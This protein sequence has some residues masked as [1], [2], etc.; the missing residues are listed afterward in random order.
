MPVLPRRRGR[1]ARSRAEEATM[2]RDAALRSCCRCLYSANMAPSLPACVAA[3]A[4]AWRLALLPARHPKARTH[5]RRRRAWN[6][7]GAAMAYP[8]FGHRTNVCL[9]RYLLNSLQAASAGGNRSPYARRR[10]QLV[11][12]CCQAYHLPDVIGRRTDAD[13]RACCMSWSTL[14]A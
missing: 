9:K 1:D 4:A 14:L 7:R 12:C 11:A 5:G 10:S 6:A 8:W 2:P 13:R 3:T